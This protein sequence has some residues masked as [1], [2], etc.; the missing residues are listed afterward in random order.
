[1]WEHVGV[2][3]DEDGLQRGIERLRDLQAT[4]PTLDVQPDAQ[5]YQDL[6]LAL[7]LRGSVVTALATAQAAR[8]RRETRGA[9]QR[10]DHPDRDDDQLVN[11]VARLTVDGEIELSSSPRPE[12]PE[13]LA[14]WATEAEE[15]DVGSRLLE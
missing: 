5:G 10:S 11:H 4:L 3:R 7:D 15:V 2:V 1:M 8:E 13:H 6:A 12:V 9:Q 14:D